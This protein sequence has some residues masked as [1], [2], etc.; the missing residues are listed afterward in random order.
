MTIT[1]IA[2]IVGIIVGVIVG[3]TTFISIF[4]TIIVA[5]KIHNVNKEL[6]SVNAA[7]DKYVEELKI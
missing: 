2:N 5:L 4:S 3:A 1:S 7:L 6:K